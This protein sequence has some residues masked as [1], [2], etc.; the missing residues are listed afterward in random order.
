MLAVGFGES[1]PGNH[2]SVGYDGLLRV[3]QAACGQAIRSAGIPL[4]DIAGAGFGIAGYDWPTQKED[5]LRTLGGLG[6]RAP[7]QIVNDA[8][9]G[10]VAGS[11]ES[12]GVAIV[13]HARGACDRLWH[14]DG[15]GG[16]KLRA[17]VPRCAGSFV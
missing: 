14:P 17:D 10:L 9:L 7:L 6:L 16:W 12:W 13:A 5:H 8:I 4:D 11:P 15:G 3:V 2:E 1:G